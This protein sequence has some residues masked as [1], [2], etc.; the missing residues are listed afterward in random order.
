M[1]TPI[2]RIW[3]GRN[4]KGRG[5]LEMRTTPAEWPGLFVLCG[6][7]CNWMSLLLAAEAQ[8]GRADQE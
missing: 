1:G 4:L 5:N 7:G 2:M 8:E 6:I 3:C